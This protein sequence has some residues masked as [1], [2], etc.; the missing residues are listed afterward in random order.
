MRLY[1][2]I[3]SQMG[4]WTYYIVRMKMNEIASEVK[5]AYDIHDDPTLSLALQRR[6]D[7]RR[8]KNQI[9][10][11]LE[12]RPD[13]FF[14]SIVVA[15]V[16]GAPMWYDVEMDTGVV[17]PMIA[18]AKSMQEAFGILSFGDEPKYYALDGQHRVSAIKRILDPTSRFAKPRGFDDDQM[19]VLVVIREEHDCDD[20][21]WLRRYRRLFSS[22]NRYARKTDRDTDI[23][24]D[25]DDVFAV[26][27][28]QLITDHEFF[29]SLGRQRDSL[30]IQTKGKN[31]RAG[32]S[33]FT[34]LQTLYA[35][36]E[37][38]LCTRERENRDGWVVQ[39]GRPRRNGQPDLTMRPDEEDIDA[40]YV[41]L[42]QY[43]DA[44]FGAF[45]EM[46]EDPVMRR[47]HE[48]GPENQDLLYFWPIG[49]ELLADM[50]RAVLDDRFPEGGRA[51]VAEM[52]AALARLAAIPWDLFDLPWRHLLLVNTTKKIGTTHGRWRVRSEDRKEVVA[53]GSRLVRWL[54]GLDPDDEELES[55][56]RSLLVVRPDES[57]DSGELWLEIEAVRDRILQHTE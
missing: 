41:E 4:D 54:V 52:S 43:W 53:V 21:E 24:M 17:P 49:Q 51:S 11:F 12:R 13:R 56:W 45:P 22:L 50:V 47:Q 57:V 16:D 46:H 31:L 18:Q 14:S 37:I 35:V 26:L 33:H 8:V 40:L 42:A 5:F 10:R 6:L 29:R 34:S 32:A 28:R 1:P 27:T 36:N 9:V 38:L 30:K 44:I 39:K 19:S 7:D 48:P 20:A 15:A 23:I 25:E 2:A 3:R 55:A